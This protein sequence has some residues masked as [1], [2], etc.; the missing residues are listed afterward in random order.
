MRDI[1]AEDGDVLIAENLVHKLDELVKKINETTKKFGLD[2]VEIKT[3]RIMEKLHSIL[4]TLQD[5][6]E[7][8]DTL[9]THEEK[10]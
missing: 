1:Q 3:N 5:F 10:S 9:Q 7:L 4:S 8:C 6:E 2:F